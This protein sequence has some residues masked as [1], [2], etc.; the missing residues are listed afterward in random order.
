MNSNDMFKKFSEREPSA[1]I[2]QANPKIYNAVGAVEDHDKLTWSVYQHRKQI[3]EGHKVY[4]WI[5]GRDAG[6][7]ASGTILCDPEKRE[8]DLDDPY[9]LDAK[10]KK[11][12]RA[13]LLTSK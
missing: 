12:G 4:I 5:S 9:K 3:K 13:L 8:P 2:F 6:I 11:R 10:K 1:W 7:I